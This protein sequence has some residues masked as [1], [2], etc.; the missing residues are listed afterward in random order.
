MSIEE[1]MREE[2]E[3]TDK[4][5]INYDSEYVKEN[6]D[7][8]PCNIWGYIQELENRIKVLEN[9]KETQKT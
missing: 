8:A 9:A 6:I 2:K 3:H 5:T 7:K 4:F 1:E